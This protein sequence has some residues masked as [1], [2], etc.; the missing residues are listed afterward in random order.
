ME[1]KAFLG[2]EENQNKNNVE[3]IKME[4]QTV[5]VIDTMMEEHHGNDFEDHQD[6]DFQ[7]HRGNGFQDH[8]GNDFEGIQ[9][10]DFDDNLRNGF[11]EHRVDD[12]KNI[13]SND[14]EGQQS[15]SVE[16]SR[17]EPKNQFN[18]RLQPFTPIHPSLIIESKRRFI[19]IVFIYGILAFIIATIS[20]R[21]INSTDST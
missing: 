21:V 16:Q 20:L 2:E 6:N 14:I 3:G 15:N 17:T 18:Q 5:L 4:E 12:F 10:N 13:R 11:K 8:R 9:G 1:N 7:D 19:T